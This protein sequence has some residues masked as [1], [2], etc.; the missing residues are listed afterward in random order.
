MNLLTRKDIA[1]AMGFSVAYIRKHEARLGFD[2]ARV[3]LPGQ[4]R[5]Y[6]PQKVAEI[7]RAIA[8]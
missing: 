7:I 1:L 6:K 8:S 5:W 3:K 2:K 4:R